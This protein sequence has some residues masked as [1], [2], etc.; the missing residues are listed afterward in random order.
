MGSAGERARELDHPEDKKEPPSQAIKG[1]HS[2][3]VHRSQGGHEPG[4][5]TEQP[6]TSESGADG[7]GDL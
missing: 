7:G 2:R 3:Q 1:E 5:I 4:E 6:Q